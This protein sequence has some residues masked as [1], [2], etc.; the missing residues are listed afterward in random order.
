[1]ADPLDDEGMVPRN[2]APPP[3]PRQRKSRVQTWADRGIPGDPVAAQA[4]LSA[5]RA[6]R[7]K[8]KVLVTISGTR[9]AKEIADA[10]VALA[11]KYDVSEAQVRKRFF[12]DGVRKY[13]PE[14]AERA[15]LN[16]SPNPFDAMPVPAQHVPVY[17]GGQS[18]L[19][20][21]SYDDDDGAA[22]LARALTAEV[23]MPI[24]GAPLPHGEQ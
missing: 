23:V 20:P 5:S 16:A 17:H 3:P 10:I 1:M 13:A 6:S 9:I 18:A 14:L 12:E 11:E 4:R 7:K 2:V 21:L 24:G 19:Q 8:R 15:G 22:N